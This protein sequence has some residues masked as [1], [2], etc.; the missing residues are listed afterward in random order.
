MLKDRIASDKELIIF[1]KLPTTEEREH[2]IIG[3]SC[4]CRP[5]VEIVDESTVVIAHRT[6]VSRQADEVW[7]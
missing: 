2:F 5:T 3:R 4:R 7:K 1:H 6:I